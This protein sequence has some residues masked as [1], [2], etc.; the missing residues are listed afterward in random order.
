VCACM[1][2]VGLFLTLTVNEFADIRKLE[3]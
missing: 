1:R 3:S 2:E